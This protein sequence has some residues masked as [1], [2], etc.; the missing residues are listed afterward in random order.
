MEECGFIIRFIKFII[1]CIF[2]LLGEIVQF[3]ICLVILV[4]NIGWVNNCMNRF[5]IR[6]GVCFVVIYIVIEGV[7]NC[8]SYNEMI[9][10]IGFVL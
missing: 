8:V 4:L 2:V 6:V 7:N 3:N 9:V 5:E 10:N 1:I